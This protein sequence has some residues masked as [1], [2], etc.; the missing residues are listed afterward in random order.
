M[1][2]VTKLSLEIVV[3]SLIQRLANIRQV[4]QATRL[5]TI[6]GLS[7]L[8]W[9][10]SVWSFS[11]KEEAGLLHKVDVGPHLAR[12]VDVIGRLP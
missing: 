9:H 12:R 2:L 11:T 1:F 3:L 5:T 10:D 4:R 6:I 7:K 8:P